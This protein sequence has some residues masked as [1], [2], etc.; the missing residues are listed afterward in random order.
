MEVG[1]RKIINKGVFMSLRTFSSGKIDSN[2]MLHLSRIANLKQ[3]YCPYG[4]THVTNGTVKYSF[5]GDWCP[6]FSETWR[7]GEKTLMHLCNQTFISI[8]NFTDERT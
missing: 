2:G 7:D 6:H 1:D 4:E 8:K 3:M 5:C